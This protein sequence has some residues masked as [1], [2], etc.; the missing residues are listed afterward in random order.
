MRTRTLGLTLFATAA[1]VVSACT[2]AATPAPPTQAP[3]DAPPAT[4]A[5]ATDA[6]PPTD[7]PTAWKIGVVT[8]VGTL[9][10]KNFNQFTWE[11]AVAGATAI[12]GTAQPIVTQNSADYAKNIQA[13]IDQ[14]YDII[15]TI[16]F[17]L[18]DATAVAAKANPDVQFIGVDQAPCLNA[19]GDPDPTFSDCSGQMPA[20]YQGLVYAEQEPGYLAGIAAA[21]IT[22]SKVI[23]A[24][25]GA[26]FI[27]PV[28]RYIK[29]YIN[30]AHSVD[31]SIQ[32]KVAYVS[33]DL[34]KAFNDPAGG[35]AFATQFIQQNT[36]L[37]VL[38][39]VAGKTGNGVLAAACDAN[40]NAIGVDVDQH[41]S[42]PETAKCTV[43]SAEKKL[44]ITVQQA[45]ERVAAGT[46]QGGVIPNDAKN[47]GIGLSPYYEHA[48]MLSGA[49]A[50]IDAA[51][52]G[53]KDGSVDPC[54]PA[55]CTDPF[56]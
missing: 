27:P 16:G 37:D 55:N 11:G 18:A 24:I 4:D 8:D 1:I 12:G 41:E 33:D 13:F 48:S 31:P 42:T 7:A 43:T 44:A 39:Q 36:G 22:K 26:A 17:A 32:V 47:D 5:P 38:F 53:F 21:N 49:Q 29:G 23:G 19:N 56:E 15:V 52:A 40:I 2:G 14:D 46:A 45:I 50:A 9:D 51:F 34:N 28:V 25:G 35:K 10:D 6:P 3:T 54:S 20:N 30:G